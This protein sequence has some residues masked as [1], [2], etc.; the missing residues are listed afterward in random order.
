MPYQDQN[1]IVYLEGENSPTVNLSAFRSMEKRKKIIKD[2][3]D[4]TEKIKKLNKPTIELIVEK[5][6]SA[7]VEID[8]NIERRVRP[9]NIDFLSKKDKNVTWL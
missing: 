2:L 3:S 4:Q 1:L 9:L 7:P 8:N 6:I 5:P